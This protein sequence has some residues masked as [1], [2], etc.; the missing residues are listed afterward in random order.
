MLTGRQPLCSPLTPLSSVF[1]PSSCLSPLSTAFTYCNGGWGVAPSESLPL[2]VYPERCP[3]GATH[4][5]PFLFINL[6]IAF[7][8]I[9]VFSQPSALPG[10]RYSPLGSVTNHQSRVTNHQSQVTPFLHVAHSWSPTF[11]RESLFSTACALFCKIPGVPPLVFHRRVRLPLARRGGLLL[12]F[13]A[14]SSARWHPL[15]PRP[16]SAG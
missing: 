15:L 5:L 8:A 2:P 6:R 16:S 4:H 7:R 14:G 9:P 12:F 10:E 13:T 3:R 1:T 11:V